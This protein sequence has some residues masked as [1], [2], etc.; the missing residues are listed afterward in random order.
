MVRCWCTCSMALHYTG[1]HI[2]AGISTAMGMHG[3]PIKSDAARSTY[4]LGTHG[5]L[6]LW[7]AVRLMQGSLYYTLYLYLYTATP[8]NKLLNFQ[9]HVICIIIVMTT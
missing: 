9:N 3:T 7:H 4:F 2:I 8:T 6:H 1:T 5:Q